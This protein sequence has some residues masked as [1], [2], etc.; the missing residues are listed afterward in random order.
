[1]QLRILFVLVALFGSA[2]VGTG[3]NAD[4]RFPDEELTRV[5]EGRADQ[6]ALDRDAL[7][8]EDLAI[9]FADRTAGLKSKWPQ[10]RSGYRQVRDQCMTSLF[11]IVAD[12]HGVSVVEVREAASHRERSFDVATLGSFAVLFGL[13]ASRVNRRII[14][15]SL[16]TSALASTM[17]LAAASVALAIVGFGAANVWLGLAETI[18]LGNGH[19]SYRAE[20]VP[21]RQ[22]PMAMF[23]AGLVLFWL[24]AAYHSWTSARER[25]VFTPSR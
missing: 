19:V 9:R 22:H 21:L 25:R 8:A 3:R 6:S 1:M 10:G 2:C 17:A 15:G 23:L 13:V 7:L 14:Q 11:A 16:G 24:I 20:R 18:R 4:C 12:H 5:S